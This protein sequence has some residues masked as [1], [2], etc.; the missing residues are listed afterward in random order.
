MKKFF[1]TLGVLGMLS[2][3]VSMAEAQQRKG[4]G[5]RPGA[6]G[7]PGGPPAFGQV[8]PG[9]LQARLN[10]TAEQ[11]KEVAALQKDVDERLAKILTTK[12]KKTLQEMSRRGPGRFGPPGGPGGPPPG[13]PGGGP[14]PDGPGAP[15]DGPGGFP[16]DGPGGPPQEDQP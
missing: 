15:P 6:P 11:K 3:L 14:P 9:F 2:L 16:P 5:S 12:Q 13:G 4:R 10:L 1:V 8:L 7:R